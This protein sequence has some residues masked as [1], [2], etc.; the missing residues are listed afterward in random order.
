MLGI[1]SFALMTYLFAWHWKSGWYL[2]MDPAGQSTLS[3]SLLPLAIAQIAM[4]FVA[5]FRI[6]SIY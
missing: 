5:S 3:W 6:K 2:I 4:L 1:A